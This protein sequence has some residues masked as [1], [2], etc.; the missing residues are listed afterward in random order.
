MRR[1]VVAILGEILM[2]RRRIVVVAA[3]ACAPR[4][5]VPAALVRSYADICG[6]SFGLA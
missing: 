4:A 2:M 6:M 1:A 3:L 5:M